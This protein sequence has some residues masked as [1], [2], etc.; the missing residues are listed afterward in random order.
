MLRKR[1]QRQLDAFRRA[2][3][4]EHA[5]G[6][7]GHAAAVQLARDGFARGQDPDRGRV[8]VVAVAHRTRDRFDHVRRRV[9]AED[10]GV[11]DVQVA[12]GLAGRFDLARFR[13]DVADRVCEAADA[14]RDGDGGSRAHRSKCY[15]SNQGVNLPG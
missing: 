1:R 5:V 10:D 11:A 8:A 6:R 2:R 13:D 15:Q 9:E 4:D 12:D 3:G 14:A 7:H